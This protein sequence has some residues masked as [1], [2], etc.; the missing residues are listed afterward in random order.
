MGRN[1]PAD[2]ELDVLVFDDGDS[3]FGT[4]TTQSDIFYNQLFP[5]NRPVNLEPL[6]GNTDLVRD[7]D[8]PNLYRFNPAR[9]DGGDDD[10]R[11]DWPVEIHGA[12]LEPGD[13][14]QVVIDAKL[15]CATDVDV[16]TFH[17]EEGQRIIVDIDAETLFGRNGDTEILVGIYNGDFEAL[18]T[19]MD[20]SDDVL[21]PTAAQRADTIYDAYA[22]FEMANHSG[23]VIDPDDEGW[24]TYYIV[25]STR[26]DEGA[27]SIPYQL[28]ITT[29]AP[30]EAGQLEQI[31]NPPSQLVW[32]AFDGAVAEY[33][34][35]DQG[36]LGGSP[37]V[38]NRPAFD[39]GDFG[40]AD[41][42]PELIEAIADQIEQY[43]RDAG[44]TADE[45]EFTTIEPGTAGSPYA[46]GSVYSTVIIGGKSP[47]SGLLGIAEKLDRHNED[48]TDM[49]TVFSK[50]IAEYYVQQ[51]DEDPII[52]F[53]QTVNVIANTAAHELGHILGL[54]H[55]KE[56][57]VPFN[58]ANNMMDYSSNEVEIGLKEFE[59]R[60]SYRLHSGGNPEQIGFEN[61]IDM[62]LRYIGSGTVMGE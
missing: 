48:R 36:G 28:T 6:P 11:L 56:I 25:V 29:S 61:E 2:Y 59:E 30:V 39:A 19:I 35:N 44:L 16:Y 7:E 41:R 14:G 27:E 20:E 4:D 18:A 31:K 34:L 60:N 62:L 50:E 43:Y 24:G 21:A 40:F 47:M 26:L 5:N 23:V 53:Q 8:D 45:I 46:A 12:L 55:A 10:P 22:L 37:D 54:E 58:L 51:M 15:G 52:R 1:E 32:L 17:L 9:P 33:L 49:V 13:A 42:R 3:D 38:I 57:N